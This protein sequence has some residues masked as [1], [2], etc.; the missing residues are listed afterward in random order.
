MRLSKKILYLVFLCSVTLS[1]QNRA[2]TVTKSLNEGTIENQF[3]YLIKKS[4]RYQEFKVVKITWLSQLKKSA[5]DSLVS[6]RKD[7]NSTK[8]I[9]LEKQAEINKLTNSLDVTNKNVTTLNNEKDTINFFGAF[10]SK[11]LY[12]TILWSI[13]ALLISALTTYIL[14]FN[15]SNSITKETNDSFTELEREYENHR[16][17][18]LDREQQLRRKLQDEINKQKKE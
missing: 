7:L 8:S 17:R 6:L 5:G 2:F 11:T 9:L 14:R 3:D 10:I 16:Q 15:R 18:S 4:N 13:I 12:N 1:A